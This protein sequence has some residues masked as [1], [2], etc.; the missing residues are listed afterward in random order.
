MPPIAADSA[1]FSK[2]GLAT[3][4]NITRAP[5]LLVDLH[6]TCDY[7]FFLRCDHVVLTKGKQFSFFVALPRRRNRNSTLPL[8]ISI[9]A[10][11]AS[12]LR[13]P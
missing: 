12:R 6:Y 9:N 13:S 1:S 2:N 10:V 3:G 8:A 11:E 7:V 4:S 5:L